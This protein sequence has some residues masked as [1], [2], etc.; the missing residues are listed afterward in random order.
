MMLT[1]LDEYFQ[2]QCF[3]WLSLARRF[4]SLSCGSLRFL[5]TTVSQGSVATRL[6]CGGMLNHDFTIT[7]SV[8]ET[9]L[10]IG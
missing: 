3:E 1:S 10:K 4:V 5:N 2:Q 7:K 8:G 6:V 9:I